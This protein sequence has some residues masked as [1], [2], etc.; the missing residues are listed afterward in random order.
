MY[1]AIIVYGKMPV[2]TTDAINENNSIVRDVNFS[3]T[4]KAAGE[5]TIT[6]KITDGKLPDGLILNTDGTIT[7]T[8]TTKGIFIFTVEAENSYGKDSKEF[9]IYV[10][11]YS[12]LIISDSIPEGTINKQYSAATEILPGTVKKSYSFQFMA[13]G[14][15]PMTWEKIGGTIPSGLKLDP[16]SGLLS[17][18]IKSAGNS[19]FII[20]ASNAYGTDSKSFTISSYM[21]PV[22]TT[23]I[24]TAAKI[25]KAYN[26]N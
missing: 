7:G 19:T 10:I 20:Q 3:D 12:P 14:S 24:L 15:T 26:K 6:W 25:D 22:I 21:P 2:I 8:P 9:T 13:T 16:T 4:L 18:T 5:E 23:N 17:G 11:D 1:L